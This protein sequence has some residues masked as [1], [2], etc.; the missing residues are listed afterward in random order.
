MRFCLLALLLLTALPAYA[1]D[2]KPICPDRPGKGTSACTVEPG[3]SQFELGLFDGSFQHRAGITTDIGSVGSLLA[4]VGVS[5]KFDLEA[6]MALQQAQ[7]LH[8]SG[9]AQTS[10]GIGDLV[11][12][13]KYDPGSGGAFAWVLDPFLKLPT[14]PLSL[15]NGK[16]EGGL[17]VPLSYDLGGNW[18]LAATPEADLLH[19]SSRAGLHANLVNVVG[20]GR[21]FDDGLSLGAEVWTDE[22]LDPAGSVSEDS[23]DLDAAFQADNDTQWDCGVNFGLN[24]AT[25]DVEIYAGISRRF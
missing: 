11:L 12:H 20:L 16:I 22:N 24:K 10:S 1:G 25:P 9:P 15:S 23:F 3:H 19:N 14:A 13:A 21:S 18:S 4:K 7:R 5:E 6:G 8:G 17:A 2:I